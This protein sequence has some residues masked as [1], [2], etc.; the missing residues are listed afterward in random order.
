MTSAG[1][2]SSLL[3]T[4]SILAAATAC[5]GDDDG[6]SGPSDAAAIIDSGPLPDARQGSNFWLVSCGADPEYDAGPDTPDAGTPDAG[7]DAG[8][9]ADAGLQPPP[10][11]GDPCCDPDGVCPS[12]L[13]CIADANR[14]NGTCRPV[15]IGDDN[16]QCPFGGVCARFGGQN[17][18]IP[19][20]VDGDECDPEL[21]E[22]GFLCVG[23]SSDDA[24]CRKK[25]TGPDDC[26]DGYECQIVSNGMMACL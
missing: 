17:I 25:C 6:G 24:V 23:T 7:V 12:G 3:A 1:I 16:L 11:F 10:G 20:S 2:L 21:C 14:E 8:P 15:C 18:C 22:S 5:G 13:E 9:P 26:G 19:A 4:T